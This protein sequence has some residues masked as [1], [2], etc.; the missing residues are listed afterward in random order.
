MPR[1]SRRPGPRRFGSPR[2]PNNHQLILYHRDRRG[3][4]RGLTIRLFIRDGRIHTGG[5]LGRG[6]LRRVSTKR[7]SKTRKRIRMRSGRRRRRQARCCCPKSNQG[8]SVLRISKTRR[9]TKRQKRSKN[10]KEGVKRKQ[11]RE[12]W[13][14]RVM[15]RQS[16]RWKSCCR[17]KEKDRSNTRTA[18]QFL[19]K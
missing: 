14:K 5:R 12:K 7:C 16:Q 13:K 15:E 1:R 8:K 17:K 9:A 2:R 11:K 10:R 18:R 3:M 19:Q 4:Q 6:T